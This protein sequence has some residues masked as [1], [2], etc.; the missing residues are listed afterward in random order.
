MYTTAWAWRMQLQIGENIDCCDEYGNWFT[1]FVIE[2]RECVGHQAGVDIDGTPLRECLIGFRY[3]DE[4]FGT[5]EDPIDRR[6]YVGWG[7]KYDSW[8]EFTCT[9]IHPPNSLA[10]KYCEVKDKRQQ[11]KND[12]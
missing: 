8:R 10:N 11:P 5:R 1:A 4:E 6:K 2:I 9:S 3:Y 12:V 7:S